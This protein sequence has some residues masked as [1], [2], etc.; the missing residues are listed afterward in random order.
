MVPIMPIAMKRAPN[1]F[2]V[3]RLVHIGAP[4]P[5][6]KTNPHSLFAV[7]QLGTDTG[8][9]PAM[10]VVLSQ[11]LSDGGGRSVQLPATI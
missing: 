11:R 9:P 5:A 2:A 7:Q 3:A 8:L 6:L 10:N 4:M 1:I